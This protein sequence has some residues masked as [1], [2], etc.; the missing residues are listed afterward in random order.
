MIETGAQLNAQPRHPSRLQWARA[1][2]VPVLSVAAIGC[3]STSLSLSSAHIHHQSDACRYMAVP[4]T[5]FVSAYGGLLAAA[6]ALL[7]HVLM[8]RAARRGGLRPTSG[9]QTWVP[10]LFAVI[11]GF[12]V[13][14]TAVV[15]A[16]THKD[17]AETA[18]NLGKPLCE[19]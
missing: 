2:P 13:P 8:S 18:A 11:A 3:F 15:V 7:V 19:G 14:L 6:L 16:L 9:W 4:W 1:L 12:M 10:T 5:H 17:A